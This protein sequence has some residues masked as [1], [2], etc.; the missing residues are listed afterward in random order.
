M[1]SKMKSLYLEGYD[2]SVFD[3]TRHDRVQIQVLLNI[4]RFYSRYYSTR[5][6]INFERVL[7]SNTLEFSETAINSRITNGN[8]GQKNHI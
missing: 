4:F 5:S 7:F 6:C 1:T 3:L 8:F 2:Y